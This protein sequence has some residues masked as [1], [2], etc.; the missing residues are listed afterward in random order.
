MLRLHAEPEDLPPRPEE[1]GRILPW[2][3][4]EAG[5]G[6]AVDAILA[7]IRPRIQSAEQEWAEAPA[8]LDELL[9]HTPARRELLVRNSRRF[10]SL[11]LCGLLLAR[12][13]HE[14]A[15]S[16]WQGERLAALALTLADSLD[17]D[18]Y[19]DWALADA[20]ARCWMQIGN[21][22][23]LAA[24]L[25]GAE[26]AFRAAEAHLSQGTGDWEERARLAA[27]RTRLGRVRPGS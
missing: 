5:N 23:R 6:P 3:A 25:P 12:S 4:P 7:E 20:R 17:A 2:R 19:G 26:R 22:R 27:L 13:H 15:D 14:S 21:A 11:A 8:L 24:D 18:W 9:R 16:P 1:G 10:Q